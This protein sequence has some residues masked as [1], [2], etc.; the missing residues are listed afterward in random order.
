MK[1]CNLCGSR[2][3]ANTLRGELN[4]ECENCLNQTPSNPEDSLRSEVKHRTEQDTE[5]YGV[6][7]DNAGFDVAGLRVEKKCPQCKLPYLTQIYVG[8]SYISKYVCECGYKVLS[9]DY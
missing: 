2:L 3:N 6:M 9:K 4:F 5:K 7:E 1:F 8:E